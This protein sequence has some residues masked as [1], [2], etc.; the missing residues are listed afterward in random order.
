MKKLM[1]MIFVVGDLLLLSQSI[2]AE[3]AT[4]YLRGKQAFGQ[5]YPIIEFFKFT[6]YSSNRVRW[7]EVSKA[8]I[9]IKPALK[10]LKRDLGVDLLGGY[11]EAVSNKNTKGIAKISAYLVYLAIQESLKNTGKGLD[12]YE[13]ASK[14]EVCTNLL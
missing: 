13:E 14:L 1:S 8:I 3:T 10:I 2:G 4:N 11:K 12:D 5:K 6:V 9:T 7:S